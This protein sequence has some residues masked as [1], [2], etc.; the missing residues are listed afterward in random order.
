MSGAASDDRDAS[1]APGGMARRGRS[2][3]LRLRPLGSVLALLALVQ[4]LGWAGATAGLDRLV[5][6]AW[7]R[8]DARA[9]PAD[10]IIAAIDEDSLE[11]LGRWPWSRDLQS[12]VLRELARLGARAVIVDVVHA[13]PSD[14]LGADARLAAALD[15]LPVAVLPVRLAAGR[16]RWARDALPTPE[17]A[18]AADALGHVALPIDADGIVRRAH[19]RAGVERAHWSSLALAAHEALG[20]DLADDPPGRRLDAPDGSPYRH[21]RDLEVMIPFY[22]PAGTFGRVSVAA[23]ARG[24]V[25]PEAVAG[26]T[27]VFGLTAD[28]LGD[29]VPVPVS[30]LDRPMPGVEVHATLHAALA[31][32]SLVVAAPE[33]SGLA[34]AAVLLPPLLLGYSRARPGFGLGLALGGA[35]VPIAASAALYGVADLWYPPVGASVA[36]L[37]SWLLWSRHRLSFVNRFLERER[38]ALETGLSAEKGDADE[39]L[40]GFFEHAREH[41]A[42]AGWRFDA[43]G[44]RFSGGRP[45]GRLPHDRGAGGWREREGLW[46]RRYRVPG[47]LEIGL[48]IDDRAFAEPFVRYVDSLARVR[49]RERPAPLLGAAERLEANAYRLSE[50]VTRLRGVKTFSETL[51]AGVPIGLAVWSP[52]GEVVRANPRVERLV[53]G[54]A[55]RAALADFLVALG[56]C[57][58]TDAEA[59]ARLDALLLR[60]EPWQIVAER[61]EL[62]IV[63]DLSAVGDSLER[64]L[65]CASLVDVSEIRSVERAR[66]ELV[67]YLS[68]D[69]RS[70]LISALYLVEG[71]GHAREAAE[72]AAHGAAGAAGTAGGG[73]CGAIVSGD[74]PGV[75]AAGDRRRDDDARRVAA[76]IRKSLAMM[77]DLLHVARA[78]A[79]EPSAFVEV[80]L[81]AVVDN[82]LDQ[83]APQARGRGIR[84]VSEDGGRE[85]EGLWVLGDA[86]SLERAVANIVGNAIKYS[87]DG[88][89]V[90]VGLS[91]ERLVPGIAPGVAPGV[92]SSDA[93]A[94]GARALLAVVDEGVGID[95]DVI[96]RLFVRF[97]RDARTADSHDGIGLGLALVSRVV[98]SHG[99]EVS[100]TSVAGRG[101]EIRL[102]LPLLAV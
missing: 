101:T 53:P 24:A 23:L 66:A 52:V 21:V 18:R 59:R 102:R 30:A 17:I 98:T 77:D 91:R 38:A 57:P 99:G 42:L 65:I 32:G 40:A 26:R 64:R 15:S 48:A 14:A 87:R 63:V 100:A 16:G 20:S 76:N 31:D 6:D 80:L 86:S 11:E 33:R 8:L 34:V 2:V 60:G 25:T 4:G 41:L 93:P 3:L 27:V 22:G 50:Q 62:E 74:G 83:L 9:P 85:D 54:L 95:P 29:S 84:L 36:A 72:V 45:V 56:R 94:G 49:S 96:D 70:P 69:L 5:H 58:A 43:G 90:R 39:R 1:G 44:R 61:D 78:D 7:V 89:T 82:A 19:L 73:P 97:R 75:P 81:D 13:E 88:G 68:H 37:A 51:L 55:P 47:G 28:G 35:L 10:V 71:A 79:L 92:A 46:W 12:V 67:D